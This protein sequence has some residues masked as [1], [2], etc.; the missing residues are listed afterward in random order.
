MA[1]RKP[2]ALQ[3]YQCRNVVFV[4]Y[5]VLNDQVILVGADDH[6]D[7]IGQPVKEQTHVRASE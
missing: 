6:C 4:C 3:N 5:F 1:L 2:Q 7:P